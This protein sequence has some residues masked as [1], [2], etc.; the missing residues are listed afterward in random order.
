MHAF[1]CM[2]MLKDKCAGAGELML[3]NLQRNLQRLA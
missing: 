1:H 3:C 2:W